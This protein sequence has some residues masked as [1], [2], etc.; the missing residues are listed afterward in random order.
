MFYAAPQNKMK[1]RSL[2]PS[3][4]CPDFVLVTVQQTMLKNLI[5]K[6]H[7]GQQKNIPKRDIL[8]K[9]EIASGFCSSIIVFM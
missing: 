1:Y 2:L 9:S 4:F 6:I 8:L 3:F 5:V 7:E